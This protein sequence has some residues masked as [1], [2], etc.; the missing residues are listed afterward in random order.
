MRERLFIILLLSGRRVRVVLSSAS[1]KRCAFRA[2]PQRAAATQWMAG[3]RL[4]ERHQLTRTKWQLVHGDKTRLVI[5]QAERVAMLRGNRLDQWQPEAVPG[6]STRRFRAHEAFSSALLVSRHN[7]RAVVAAGD[8]CW[9]R[10]RSQNCAAR[11]SRA[12]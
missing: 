4:T 5:A 2:S 11:Y 8:A 12:D 1:G 10:F 7:A 9:C 3:Y 6:V